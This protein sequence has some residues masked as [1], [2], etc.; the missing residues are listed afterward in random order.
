MDKPDP[1]WRSYLKTTNLA[2]FE[3]ITPKEAQAKKKREER[4]KGKV[5][6]IDR[7]M[8]LLK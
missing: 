3:I 2:P 6:T 1:I 4:R 7:K 8:K 5:I